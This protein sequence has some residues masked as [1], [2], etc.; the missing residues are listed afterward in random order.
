MKSGRSKSSE[1]ATP[2]HTDATAH[3]EAPMSTVA[4]ALRSGACS[5]DSSSDSPRLDAELLLGKILGLARS[6][7]IAHDRESLVR[8]QEQAYMNLVERRRQGAPVAY[9]T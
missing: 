4:E 8:E 2:H 9:L 7:L 3:P 6:G 1:H 5:L